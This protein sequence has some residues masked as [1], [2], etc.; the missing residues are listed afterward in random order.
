MSVP[1]SSLKVKEADGVMK[2]LIENPMVGSISCCLVSPARSVKRV[3]FP[4]PL[5]PK[6]STESS[7]LL[8]GG[9]SKQ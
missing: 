9:G 4:A 6:Q 3:D 2:A 5:R 8:G 7:G 1:P